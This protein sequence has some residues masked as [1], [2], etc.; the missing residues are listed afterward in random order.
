M[1]GGQKGYHYNTNKGLECKKVMFSVLM[2]EISTIHSKILL[3]I[4]LFSSNLLHLSGATAA[5]Q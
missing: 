4:S 5:R 3:V 2:H 1:L